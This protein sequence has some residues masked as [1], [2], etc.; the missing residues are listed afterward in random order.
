MQGANL[1]VAKRQSV[2]VIKLHRRG[3]DA[4]PSWRAGFGTR[5]LSQLS[6][7]GDVI[8]MGMGFKCPYQLELVCAQHVQVTLKLRVHGI[9]DHRVTRGVVKQYVGVGAGSRVKKLN[10]VH[11]GIVVRLTNRMQNLEGRCW[12]KYNFKNQAAGFP[13]RAITRSNWVSKQVK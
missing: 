2:T 13:K 12:L 10:G 3:G 11:D 9:N 7:A 4:T 5:Q 1:F 6:G 8:R